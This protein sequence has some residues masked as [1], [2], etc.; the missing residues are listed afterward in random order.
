MF[1]KSGRQVPA[2]RQLL[3]FPNGIILLL[4]RP[5]RL[6]SLDTQHVTVW[7][8]CKC[9][10]HRHTLCEYWNN[11]HNAEMQQSCVIS[12]VSRLKILISSINVL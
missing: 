1:I 5:V 7:V 8:S 6:L 12:I 11:F 2:S 3:T 9:H 10:A 4:V